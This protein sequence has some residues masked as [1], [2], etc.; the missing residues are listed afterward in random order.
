VRYEDGK[1]WP[2]K[3]PEFNNILHWKICIYA[4]K[5]IGKNLFKKTK[6]KN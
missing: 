2:K 1:Q 3:T 4:W 5:Y 6:I